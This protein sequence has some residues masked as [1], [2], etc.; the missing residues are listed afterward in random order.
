[1]GTERVD[2][3]GDGYVATVGW[4]LLFTLGLVF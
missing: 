3:D 4:Y 1:M 2:G